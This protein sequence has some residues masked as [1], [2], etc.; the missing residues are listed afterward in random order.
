MGKKKEKKLMQ[1]E[2]VQKF[3]QRWMVRSG[4]KPASDYDTLMTQENGGGHG[5]HSVRCKVTTKGFNDLS[6]FIVQRKKSRNTPNI[7][8]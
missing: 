5:R 8:N 6:T 4:V 2:I 7:C 1:K 3:E